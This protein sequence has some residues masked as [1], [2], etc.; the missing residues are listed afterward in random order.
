MRLFVLLTAIGYVMLCYYR[1][2][3]ILFIISYLGLIMPRGLTLPLVAYDL[4]VVVVIKLKQ[5]IGEPRVQGPQAPS[6]TV[7]GGEGLGVVSW[8]F[9]PQ[10]S[11]LGATSPLKRFRRGHVARPIGEEEEEKVALKSSLTIFDN[12]V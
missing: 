4:T 3:C 6:G 9:L 5:S 7:G 1:P 8:S 11:Y 10:T 12:F 2:T